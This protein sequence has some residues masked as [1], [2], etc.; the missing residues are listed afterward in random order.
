MSSLTFVIGRFQNPFN[1]YRL[2]GTD[3][4]GAYKN[5]TRDPETGAFTKKTPINIWGDK[6]TRF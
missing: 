3:R 1:I 5:S 4:N 6:L 2:Q